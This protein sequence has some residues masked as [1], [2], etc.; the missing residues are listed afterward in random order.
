MSWRCDHGWHRWRLMRITNRRLVNTAGLAPVHRCSLT[1]RCD[2]PGCDL[3]RTRDDVEDPYR[4]RVKLLGTS[5]S[6][7]RGLNRTAGHA[8]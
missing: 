7:A 6:P 1:E 2:R 8:P 4:A 3:V 5:Q